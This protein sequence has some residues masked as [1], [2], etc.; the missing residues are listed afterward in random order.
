MLSQLP[1]RAFVRFEIGARSNPAV[2]QRESRDGPWEQVGHGP[3]KG[4]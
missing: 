4:V 2:G 1:L 3:E